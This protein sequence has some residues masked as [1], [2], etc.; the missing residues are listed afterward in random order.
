MK[1]FL[2]SILLFPLLLNAQIY[3]MA[4]NRFDDALNNG[5]G[6]SNYDN[7]NATLAWGES[8]IMMSY[9][10]MYSAT[11][12]NFYLKRLIRHIDNV[13]QQRDDNAGRIDYRGISGATWVSTTY[14]N[15]NPY[16]W[17][18]HDGMLTFPMAAFAQTVIN[19]PSLHNLVS[20]TGGNFYTT[21]YFITIANDL[22]IQVDSTIDAHQD[23]WV[24]NAFGNNTGAY[25]FRWDATAQTFLGFPG[26]NMPLNQQNALG[27]TLVAMYNA[28]GN[29]DY[30]DK[31]TRLANT[32]KNDL[33]YQTSPQAYV[34]SYWGYQGSTNE[35]ISHAAI[36]SDFALQCY[37]AGIVF[38]TSDMQRFASTFINNIYVEP[39][40]VNDWVNGAGNNNLYWAQTGRWVAF[41]RFNRDIYH[42]VSDLFLDAALNNTTVSGSWFPAMAN[43]HH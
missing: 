23:Q 14:T 31:A 1:P 26:A 8:Y 30:L 33:V 38:N 3:H 15:G 27:R 16:A 29:A 12:D 9:L 37:D 20:D 41:S 21:T 18:V 7:L 42:V 11:Q 4:F 6:Y 25:R 19:N 10:S 35:D 2:F 28:T 13:L 43:L 32:F 5:M 36:N 24:N 22:L 40:V 34:W 17:L 39:L